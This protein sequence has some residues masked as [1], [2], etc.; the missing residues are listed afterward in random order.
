MEEKNT[1]D[2]IESNL[3][4]NPIKKEDE[5]SI[6]TKFFNNFNFL[7]SIWFTIIIMMTFEEHLPQL[8]WP[9]YLDKVLIFTFFFILLFSTI[10]FLKPLIISGLVL[11]T[12]ILTI[13]FIY[14]NEKNPSTLKDNSFDIKSSPADINIHLNHDKDYLWD[15]IDSLKSY[16][17]FRD[18]TFKF[19]ID[20]LKMELDFLKK[21]SFSKI[22]DSV[23]SKTKEN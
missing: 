20:S 16:A 12:I 11:G 17:L 7:V 14:S 5:P 23:I 8:D 2:N 21:K 9:W 10:D 4:N 18:S 19:Q 22:P 6:F 15:E 3:D 13:Y 1:E